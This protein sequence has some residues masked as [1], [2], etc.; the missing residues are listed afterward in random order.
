[1]KAKVE[2]LKGRPEFDV[3]MDGQYVR[4]VNNGLLVEVTREGMNIHTACTL[5]TIMDVIIQL[6][7][8][9]KDRGE[10][11][12]LKQYKKFRSIDFS[13][14]GSASKAIDELFEMMRK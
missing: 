4:R 7:Q 10:M 2:E 8:V 6:E 14:F 13:E 3:L 5:R 1:M 12:H 11:E 9:V